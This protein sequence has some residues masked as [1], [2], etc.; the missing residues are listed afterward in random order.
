[1]ANFAEL[2]RIARE[3]FADIVVDVHRIDAKLRVLVIDESYVDFWWSEVQE[4][5]FAHHWNRQQVDGAI[6]RHDNS[7]HRRWAYISTFPRH[8]HR[9][10][11]ESVTESF[12]P[13]EPPEAVRAFLAFCREVI[14]AR[15]SNI[16]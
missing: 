2:E 12:L 6:Y 16:P 8:Y 14:L 13:E 7:P 11:E 4:G 9:E 1:M 5:R 15:S 3:E 10:R